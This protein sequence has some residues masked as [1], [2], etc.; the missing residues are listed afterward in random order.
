[1]DGIARRLRLL[2]KDT[3]PRVDL[4]ITCAGEDHDTVKNTAEVVCALDYPAHRLRVFILDDAGSDELCKSMRTLT[5]TRPGCFYTA[6]VKGKDHHFKAGNLNY[7][8]EFVT[9]LPAGPAD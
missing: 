2:D 8:V 4:F 1:M 9:S 3:T 5:K 7:G 6:R